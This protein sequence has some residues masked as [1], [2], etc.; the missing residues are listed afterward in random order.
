MGQ[1]AVALETRW[2]Y[3]AIGLAALVVAQFFWWNSKA[4]QVLRG[5]R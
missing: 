1:D 4:P 5:R 2:K 3:A